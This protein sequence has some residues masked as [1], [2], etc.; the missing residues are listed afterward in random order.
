MK[1]VYFLGLMLSLGNAKAQTN[2][3]VLKTDANGNTLLWEVSG[4]GLTEPGYLFGTFHLLCKDDI[5]FSAAL[6]QAISNSHEIYLELDLDDP[7]TVMGALM[8]MNMKDGKKLKDLYTADQYK[9]VSDFFKDSLK[10]PIS[11]FQRMKPEFLIALLYPKMMPCNAASSVEEA[12][13]Q[14]AKDGGKEIK[15]LET[16]AFQA[17]VFDSIPY[18]KQ[19][20]ELLNT[21]DSLEKSK[22]DFSLMLNAYKQQR[23]DE[24][25]KI[26]NTP[27]FG[28]AENQDILLDNRNKNW[29]QQ[30]KI[31]MKKNPVFTAVGAGHL[32]GKNGLIALLRA[33][34]FIVRGLENK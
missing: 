7:A 4:N 23:L 1:L 21:I 22:A 32:V 12:I 29:I 19:A 17:S 20:A 6:K 24:I 30:L 16:M 11:L 26:V 13:M 8:L 27:E 10:T 31:I 28:A 25:E 5:N 18:E 2:N 34:G 3:N 15:G 14:L 9:R 33:E